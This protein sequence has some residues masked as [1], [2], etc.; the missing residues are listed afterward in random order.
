[1]PGTSAVMAFDGLDA[2]DG[3]DGVTGSVLMAQTLRL[4]APASQPSGN[5][6]SVMSSP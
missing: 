2:P 1:M 3:P 6:R 5:S 4:T